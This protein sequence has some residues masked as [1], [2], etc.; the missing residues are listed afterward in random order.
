MG[1][2]VTF[3]ERDGVPGKD[4]VEFWR[5]LTQGERSR[6]AYLSGS[7][8]ASIAHLIYGHRKCSPERAIIIANAMKIIKPGTPAAK[9]E[10]WCDTCAQCP[11]SKRK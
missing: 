3:A 4:A 7:A 5:S 2:R 6:L 10:W 9:R 8:E 11:Y 1:K